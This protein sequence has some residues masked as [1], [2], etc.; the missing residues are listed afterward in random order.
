MRKR[1]LAPG[2]ALALSIAGTVGAMP[3]STVADVVIVAPGATADTAVFGRVTSVGASGNVVT[4]ETA[5]GLTELN[6]IAVGDQV[7]LLLAVNGPS[8]GG[9]VL[10]PGDAPYAG[11]ASTMAARP[12]NVATSRR[13]F[14]VWLLSL[15]GAVIV[16][17]VRR[18]RTF[19]IS[20]DGGRERV[21][22]SVRNQSPVSSYV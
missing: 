22:P 19:L 18:R 8:A 17:R 14:G 12:S 7:Q 3:A 1:L 16:L 13:L 5:G 9:T 4:I 6:A 11:S 15:S 2:V 10:L 21:G 20:A